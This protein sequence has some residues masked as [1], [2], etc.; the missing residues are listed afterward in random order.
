[1]V[2][3]VSDGL[4]V[5]EGFDAE[6]HSRSDPYLKDHL[7]RFTNE[8][9][10]LT[11]PTHSNNNHPQPGLNRM[12][13]LPTSS[14]KKQETRVRVTR[15]KTREKVGPYACIL[16]FPTNPGEIRVGSNV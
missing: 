6:L 10:P 8:C 16:R 14:R 11:S 3:L 13:H 15:E 7:Y 2:V 1:M 12:F 4:Y 5:E 9:P